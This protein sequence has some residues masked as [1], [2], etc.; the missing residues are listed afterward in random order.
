[1]NFGIALA[2]LSIPALFAS[3][4][5]IPLWNKLAQLEERELLE[6]WGEEYKN[7]MQT[8]GRFLPK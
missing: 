7:F 3:F 2:C 1:M 4:F 5:L 8:R 6:Y